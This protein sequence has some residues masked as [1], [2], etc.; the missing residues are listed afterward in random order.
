[1]GENMSQSRIPY[2]ESLR[3]IA[4]FAVLVLHVVCTPFGSCSNAYSEA[5]AFLV[6]LLRN[7]MNWGVPVFVMITGALLVNPQKALPLKKLFF[8]YIRRFVLAI[9]VFCT[10]FSLME[11][12][13]SEREISIGIFA[14]AVLNTAKAK[15]WDHTWYL[16][17]TV[18]L[19]ALLPLFR[20]FAFGLESMQKD[21]GKN[22][23]ICVLCVMFFVSSVVP[24]LSF[25]VD[26]K[27]DFPGISIYLFYLVLGYAVEKW[28]F[29]LPNKISVLIL[30]IYV[31]YICLIQL[32][33]A[34]LMENNAALNTLGNDSPFV[35]LAAFS[36]FSLCK[37]L[38]GKKEEG[39]IPAFFS[40]LTF[41]IYI[42]HPVA[43]NLCYKVLHLTPDR[44][45]FPLSLILTLIITAVFSAAGT[46]I[47]R[48]IPFVRKYLL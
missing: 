21:D 36:I 22:I 18:G 48:K 27:N 25:F 30:V 32:S 20:T 34:F 16:Y 42:I 14:R 45:S 15:S 12:V 24:Y 17:M 43:V 19:Y 13:F 47:L 6:R 44:I 3:C 4:A 46:W 10:L 26:F 23:L 9:I 2:I 35:V 39:K 37:N 7:L 29:S 31:L 41:G 40:P 28:N 11:L 5:E 38:S 33:P 8:K 1:M